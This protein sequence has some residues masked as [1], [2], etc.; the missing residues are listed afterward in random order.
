VCV[1]V[2]VCVC[3][4]KDNLQKQFF[5]FHH[6]MGGL[7]VTL[8]RSGL[9]AGTLTHLELP[10]HPCS[11]FVT[12]YPY[13][14]SRCSLEIIVWSYFLFSHL[15]LH[16]LLIFLVSAYK[17]LGSLPQSQLPWGT[18]FSILLVSQVLHLPSSHNHPGFPCY[19]H[20]F[21]G[22]WMEL[23]AHMLVQ[24]STTEFCSQPGNFLGM[25]ICPHLAGAF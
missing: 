18:R 1:C 7:G 24:F 16:C 19:R 13:T 6:V 25:L 10:A 3:R 21:S 9:V 2:C 11:S 17:P 8:T 4:S 15:F 12:T 20:F 22:L 14:T 23:S 5:P